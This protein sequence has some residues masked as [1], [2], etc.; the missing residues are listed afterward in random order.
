MLTMGLRLVTIH[1]RLRVTGCGTTRAYR[2]LEGSVGA[3][4]L[5]GVAWSKEAY[6]TCSF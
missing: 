5:Y 1:H 3:L 2:S 6:G 4:L